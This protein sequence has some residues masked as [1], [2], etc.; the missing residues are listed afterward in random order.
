MLEVWEINLTEVPLRT[1]LTWKGCAVW[2]LRGWPWRESIHSLCLRQR[3]N[4]K[5]G[6]CETPMICHGWVGVLSECGMLWEKFMEAAELALSPI[7][8]PSQEWSIVHTLRMQ[9]DEMSTGGSTYGRPTG[10]MSTVAH[11]SVLCTWKDP[12]GLGIEVTEG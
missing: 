6:S 1:C 7:L 5:Q 11:S 10:M 2:W 3:I 4:L 8:P 12:L 9:W